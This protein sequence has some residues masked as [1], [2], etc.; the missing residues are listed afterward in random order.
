MYLKGGKN[1]A[2]LWVCAWS[3]RIFSLVSFILNSPSSRAD[4]VCLH[5]QISAK[6][7]KQKNEMDSQGSPT[8]ETKGVLLFKNSFRSTKVGGDT[9]EADAAGSFSQRLDSCWSW[10]PPTLHQDSRTSNI[11][12]VQSQKRT[13][14]CLGGTHLDGQCSPAG[15]KNGRGQSSVPQDTVPQRRPAGAQLCCG[16]TAAAAAATHAAASA[17]LRQR[18]PTTSPPPQDL[19]AVMRTSAAFKSRTELQEYTV[20][21]RS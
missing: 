21:G 8:I 11:H 20:S 16:E 2:Q 10:P 5:I 14:V 6:C 7:R 9:D 12:S 19:L 3:S 18:A 13:S 17:Q 1:K 15:Q 4:F